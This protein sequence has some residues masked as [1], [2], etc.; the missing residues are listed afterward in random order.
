MTIAIYNSTAVKFRMTRIYAF[1]GLAVFLRNSFWSNQFAGYRGQWDHG[2]DFVAELTDSLESWMGATDGYAIIAL[3]GETFGHHHAKLVRSYLNEMFS[4]L[5]DATD[6][7]RTT[8]LADLYRY[9]PHALHF[10]PPGSWSTDAADVQ[11]RDY[12]SWWKGEHNKIHQ[13]Q[14][15][16]TDVILDKVR[17]ID[18]DEINAEMDRALYSDQYWWASH[19]KF[20]PEEI[21][22]GAFNMM[23][24]PATGRR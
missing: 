19:W 7:L 2:Q 12:F 18:N 21:Y 14:W 15:E 1:D 3:D 13:L 11:R 17:S 6:R 10:M 24:H 5:S 20:D 16:L 22:K 8:H 23:Q 4:A 9:F